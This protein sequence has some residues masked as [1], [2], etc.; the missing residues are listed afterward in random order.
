MPRFYVGLCARLSAAA[1]YCFREHIHP[2]ILVASDAGAGV[3]DPASS[4]RAFALSVESRAV[5]EKNCLHKQTR[6]LTVSLTCLLF[7]SRGW[8]AACIPRVG[9]HG[10]RRRL[11]GSIVWRLP[12]H[13]DNRHAFNMPCVAEL[14]PRLFS[15]HRVLFSSDD[16]HAPSTNL[17]YF[18]YTTCDLAPWTA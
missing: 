8:G 4:T 13:T 15:P 14:F 5:R 6:H 3:T 12:Y 17:P 18:T 1:Y 16:E 9:L 2:L 10:G 7:F 11:E